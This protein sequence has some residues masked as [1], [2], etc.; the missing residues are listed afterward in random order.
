MQIN[1]PMRASK[2]FVDDQVNRSARTNVTLCNR[3]RLRVGRGDGV[4]GGVQTEDRTG[5]ADQVG[6]RERHRAGAAADVEHVHARSDAGPVHRVGHRHLVVGTLQ[7]EPGLFGLA[8]T[9]HVL[10]GRV[11]PERRG[12]TEPGWRSEIVMGPAQPA[13]GPPDLRRDY[14]YR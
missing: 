13:H 6:G 4:G 14:R 9:E 7:I 5:R 2:D 1:R 11:G 10:G 12:R 8:G 3:A